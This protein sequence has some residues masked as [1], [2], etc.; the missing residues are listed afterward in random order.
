MQS[1]EWR[2]WCDCGAVRGTGRTKRM[3]LRAYK[4]AC[5]EWRKAEKKKLKKTNQ[6]GKR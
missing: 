3:A 6:K 4:R 2:A 1:A 5:A